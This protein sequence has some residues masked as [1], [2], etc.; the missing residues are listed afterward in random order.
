MFGFEYGNGRLSVPRDGRYYVYA[1]I[2]FNARPHDTANRVAV[3]AKDR[4]L[5]LIHRD[6][7]VNQEQTGFAGGI[8][9]LKAGD[10]IFLRP[11]GYDTKMWLGPN[12]AYFGAY[13][14]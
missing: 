1:Q 14:I 12:A 11:V 4:Y 9:L 5:F 10:T 6:M 2:Y 3:F 8:Y 13:K 7:K